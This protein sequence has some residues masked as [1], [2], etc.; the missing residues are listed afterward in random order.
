MVRGEISQAPVSDLATLLALVTDLELSL[1]G[2]P[3]LPLGKPQAAANLL[4]DYIQKERTRH[5]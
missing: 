3:T 5:A 1:P 2:I 4:L